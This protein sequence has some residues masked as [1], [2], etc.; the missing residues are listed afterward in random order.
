[1]KKEDFKWDTTDI[2]LVPIVKYLYKKLKMFI[3]GV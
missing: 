3:W 2:N 1:M